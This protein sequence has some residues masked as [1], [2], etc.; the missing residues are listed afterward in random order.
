MAGSSRRVALFSARWVSV[1]ILAAGMAVARPATACDRLDAL[2]AAYPEA[3]A[4]H[5]AAQVLWRD[6][7]STPVGV[8]QPEAVALEHATLADQLAEPYLAGAIA[9]PAGDPGRARNR[10]F[11]DRMYGDCGRGEVEPRLVT[12]T[13]LPDDSGQRLRVTSVNGVAAALEAVS[14]EI[15]LLPPELRR[16]AHPSAGAY[17]CRDARG[18]HAP[19]MHAYG[20][21]IDLNVGWAD[22]WRWGGGP[23]RNRMPAEVV[24]AF[25]RHGFIWGGRWRH[26]DTMHFE[27]RP[28]L[29]CY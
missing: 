6:G 24:A 7:S 3:L 4:G 21:A 20:A 14:A 2:V 18:E 15:A 16:A 12:V 26:F 13:W 23:W 28:E 29:R 10:A 5:T 27:Y 11:F 8:T 19:S 25:E 22:Y 1:A 17:L 9:E